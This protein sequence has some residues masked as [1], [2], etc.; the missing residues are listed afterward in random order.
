[1]NAAPIVNEYLAAYTSG[2]ADKAAPLVT[3]DFSFR[4][5]IRATEGRD[6]LRAIVDHL[7]PQ[8]R[9]CQVLRQWED[10]DDVCSIYEFKFESRDR[11]TS[12][13]VSE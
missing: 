10:G 7:A 8:A 11:E 4:G 13:L 5:P 6:A 1:M 9:G 3:E 2:D 12:L